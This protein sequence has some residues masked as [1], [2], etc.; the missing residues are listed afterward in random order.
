METYSGSR[1]QNAVIKRMVEIGL[2]AE[3][4]EILP[5]NRRKEMAMAGLNEDD[6]EE[7]DD[8]NMNRDNRPVK[9]V[10]SRENYSR[11]KRPKKM[12]NLSSTLNIIEV[13]KCM[14]DL[15]DDLRE[16]IEWI[17][18]SLNDAAEDAE[19]YSEDPDDGVPLV[20]FSSKQRD[21]LEV[22]SF[23]KLLLALSLYAPVQDVVRLPFS[24]FHFNVISI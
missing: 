4:A 12:T 9:I 14:K 16:S 5:K 10:K 18:E 1:S 19:E 20:P 3:R 15:T 23:Q 8:E 11:D 13:R 7:D 17:C 24:R 6:Y 22:E 2:I 21:A